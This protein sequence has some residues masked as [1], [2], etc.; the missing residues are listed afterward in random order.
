M[1]KM[2]KVKVTSWEK[3]L[4]R[5]TCHGF[6]WKSP[7]DPSAPNSN[8]RERRLDGF[9]GSVQSW[10]VVPPRRLMQPCS[11]VSDFRKRGLLCAGIT[12]MSLSYCYYNILFG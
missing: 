7:Q 5:H 4:G 8:A 3:V 11:K 2:P 10:K 1:G 12:G 6:V 9:F